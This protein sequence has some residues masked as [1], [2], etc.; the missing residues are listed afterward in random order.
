MKKMI[1]A[2][3]M[4]L[5][6]NGC[7]TQGQQAKGEGTALGALLGGV[8]GAAGGYL[9]DDEKG[10]LIG[11]AL[12]AAAGGVAGHSYADNITKRHEALSGHEYDLDARIRFA[13]GINQDTEA[14][15]RQLASQLS[16]LNQDVDRL[17]YRDRQGHASR[18]ELLAKKQKLQQQVN[19][20]NSQLAAAQKELNSLKAFQRNTRSHSGALDAEIAK[21]ENNVAQL[22]NNVNSIADLNYKL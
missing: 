22:N 2:A 8:V 14:Y 19:A 6:L 15:N 4:L 16:E 20:A 7:A 17:L 1:A 18:Q 13:E 21:L 5:L 12:G 11:A 10:A 9:I 3:I